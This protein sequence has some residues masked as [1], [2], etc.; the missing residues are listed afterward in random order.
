MIKKFASLILFTAF[1]YAVI[2]QST[3]P[4]KK[5]RPDIPGTFLI[6]LGLNTMTERPNN[7]KYGLWGSRTV[8]A[9]YQYDMRIG[10]SKF[11][12]HPGIGLGMERFKLQRF[13]KYLPNDTIDK[14]QNPTLIFDNLGNTQ[15]IETARYLYDGD[16]LGQIN[17]SDSYKTK[18]SML[19]MN[20]LDI[21][22][23]FRFSTN[24]DDPAR[25]FK[26]GI[27]GRVGY[28]IGSHSKIKY[29]ENGELKIIKDKQDFNLSPF[30]YSA[31]LRIYIGNF[32]FFGFYNF[33]P[34]FKEEKGPSKTNTATYTFGISL[35][36]F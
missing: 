18:K 19:V 16:T 17:W 21:P 6:D 28:L 33:N 30:R 11:S 9:Y 24:P 3:E 5:G 36:S 31:S 4:K 10:K 29:R 1:S 2:A 15:F 22:F 23:E 20:Y 8:N 13:S 34:M 7:L 27:G 12:F 25:S 14:V 35:S 26:V 32:N